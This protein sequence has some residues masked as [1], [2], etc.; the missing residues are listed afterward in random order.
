MIGIVRPSA[1]APTYSGNPGFGDKPSDNA[2]TTI[3]SRYAD[4]P[5]LSIVA[6]K[7]R[8]GTMVKTTRSRLQ[9]ADSQ[10]QG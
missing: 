5:N 8:A 4:W 2:P 1:L 3:R 7:D 9:G 6:S 10:I